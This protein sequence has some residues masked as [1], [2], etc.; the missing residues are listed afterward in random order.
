M[1]RGSERW[2]VTGACGRLGSHVLAQL[3]ER[4]T[5]C[6]GIRRASCLG[7]HGP[8]VELELTDRSGL[9]S[10]LDAYAP[11]HIVHLAAVTSAGAAERGPD[12]AWAVNVRVTEWL[13][14]YASRAGAHMLVASTDFVWWGDIAGRYVESDVPDGHGIYA[15]SKIAAEH[16]VLA[17]DAGVVVRYSLM[18]GLPRCPRDTLF[19]LQ[20]RRLRAH[21]PLPAVVD[22]YRTPVSLADAARATITVCDARFRGVVHV[23]GPE[24]L[25]PADQIRRYAQALEVGEP[26]LSHVLRSELDPLVRRPQNVAMEPTILA[27]DFADVL[28][29]APTVA[30]ILAAG[31]ADDLWHRAAAA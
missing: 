20:L 15:E 31:S 23:A 13:A 21:E 25:T 16:A 7:D 8:T 2:L 26:Q 29:G 1:P 5:P 18:Y 30:R 6:L 19:A 17:H 10:L 11:T 27:R 28:P 14:R 4:R 9:T 12:A 22:E 24:A 3:A